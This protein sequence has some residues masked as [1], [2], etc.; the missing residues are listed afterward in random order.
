MKA[1]EWAMACGAIGMAA[2]T[3][4]GQAPVITSFHDNGLLTWTNAVNTNAVYRVE[5]AAQ[6]DGPWYR[7]LQ[8]IPPVD[9]HSSTSFAAVVPMF[10]R[11]AMVTNESPL[12]M[13]WIEGGEFVMGC[14]DELAE[15]DEQPTHT[16]FISG[17]WMDEMEVTKWKWDEVR[18]WAAT[19][20]YT[21]SGA[22]CGQAKTN[23]HPV[24]KVLWYDAVKWCNARS[25][26]E[27]LTPCYYTDTALTTVYTQQNVNIENDKVKWDANG[28]RLPTEAEWEKAALGGRQGRRFPWGGDTVQ[29]ARANYLSSDEVYDTSSTK[30]YHPAYDDGRPPYTSPPGSFPANGFG[31]HDM[32]GNVME[33]CWDLYDVNYYSISPT[34]DPRGPVTGSSRMLRGGNCAECA[35]FL[36]CSFRYPMPPAKTSSTIGFRCVRCD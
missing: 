31:L 26:M 20:G 1:L 10:Y 11:I 15:S 18:S 2:A 35:T 22:N 28:Y 7:T 19:N 32:A 30:G 13:V 25:Q 3:V 27:R 4:W 29:H 16:N 17:F 12:G 8:S 33:W 23:S 24:G 6:I 14:S 36:R 21:F 5:W 34:V 9:A